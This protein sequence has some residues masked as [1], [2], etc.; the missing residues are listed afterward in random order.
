MH[1]MMGEG[2]SPSLGAVNQGRLPEGLTPHLDPGIG[3]SQTKKGK[4]AL[5]RGR[6]MWEGRQRQF[7]REKNLG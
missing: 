5:G 4:F 1:R 3:M 2:S 7:V 6:D